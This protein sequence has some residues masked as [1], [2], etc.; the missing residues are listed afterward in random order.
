MKR[1]LFIVLSLAWASAVSAGPP[2]VTDDPEPVDLR[3][4][5]LYLASQYQHS[6]R[7]AG[8]TLPHVE[9][10]YGIIP[11]TQFHVIA[12]LA[13]DAP[14]G[15]PRQTGYGDTELGLKYRFLGETDDRPQLGVFPLVELPTGDSSRGLGAGHT[16][17]YLPLWAQ[18]TSGKWTCY[19]GGGY[20][21]NPGAGNR[22]WWF[23]G[24]VVQ[25]QVLPNLA[26]GAEVFHETAKS[27][28]VGPDTRANL[29]LTWDLSE[30]S[31]ILA[32]AGPGLSGAAG[33]QTYVAFQLTWG[34]GK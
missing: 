6:S 22:D 20:W 3:H 9:F 32:S 4:Y 13:F 15:A 18:K 8:G 12:P 31:H 2:F 34:P 14:A 11:E 5:E 7:D 10:N 19:G 21:I 26:V 30:G 23:A 33:Y 17:I 28:S 1:P 29:G 24:A 25:R 16:Q 27:D